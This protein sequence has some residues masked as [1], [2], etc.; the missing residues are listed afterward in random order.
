MSLEATDEALSPSLLL[1][2][3]VIENPYPFYRRLVD[4]APV[5]CVPG[6]DIV[7]ISSFDAVAE[8]VNRVDDFSSN[9]HSL[10][11]CNDAGDPELLPFEAGDG[12]N[13][14]A[15][16]DPPVHTVHRSTVFPELV[17]RRMAELRSDIELL[18]QDR[19]AQ[20]LTRSPI[21]IMDEIANAIPIRVVS[22]LIGFRA[23]DPERL[24][25]AA[26][27][28]T[29]ML[30]ATQPL[31]EILTRME[32][33]AEIFFWIGDQLQQAMDGGGEGIL[34]VIATAVN[35]GDME[36]GEGLVIMHTLLSAG[37]ESTTSLLGNAIHLLAT[38]PD[39]QARLRG[40]TELITPFI[41]EVL[42]LESPFRYH[43]RHAAQTSELLGVEIRAG[44][45]VLLLW[46]AANRDPSKFDRP[47]EVVLDRSA[48]RLHLGFGRGI[49]HCVGAPL[50]R[51]EAQI[52]LTRFLEQTAQFVLDPH[53]PPTRVQSLMVRRFSSLPLLATSSALRS[54]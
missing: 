17:A 2:P 10:V 52:V 12:G 32:R 15:T 44:S 48:P 19:I 6:T 7:V 3:D 16:A 53:Y 43:L 54:T 8:A 24:L 51:L 34:G 27:D 45:T 4:E 37:G 29:A 20:A 35:S 46:A 41:E 42:R 1:D 39:L 25:D 9:I 18:V 31:S 5:W 50:A 11:Y 49:H 30:A 21:E 14:L 13:A 26:F 33:T 40:E 38:K 36:L 22:K 23:E 28:S 47:N